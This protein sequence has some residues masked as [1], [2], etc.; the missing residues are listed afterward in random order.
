MSKFFVHEKGICE[1]NTIGEGTRIWAFSHVQS[2][3][4]IGSGCNL[5]EHVFVESGVQIGNGCTIKNGVAIWNQVTLEDDVFV[6][7]YVVFTN[8]IT[9]RAFIKRGV[10]F[11]RP[12]TI[13]KGATLGA[14]STIVCGYNVGKYALV[15]AGAVVVSDIPDHGLVVGNPGRVIGRVCFCGSRLDPKDYCSACQLPLQENS[16][17]KA[18]DAVLALARAAG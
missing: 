5:G 16:P 18:K 10:A 17:D 12:V 15:G 4:T 9:P 13:G 11:Y 3:V 1:S 8:D 14:N 7:P 6:G 2:N